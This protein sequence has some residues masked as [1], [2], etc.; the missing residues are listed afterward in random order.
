MCLPC[1]HKHLT[2]YPAGAWSPGDALLRLPPGG[3]TF[4]HHVRLGTVGPGRDAFQGL[5]EVVFVGESEH[6]F[7]GISSR[8]HGESRPWLLFSHPYSRLAVDTPGL[9]SHCALCLE[10]PSCAVM[11][12]KAPG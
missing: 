8:S 10:C 1:C 11:Q 6:T 5:N 4:V 2:L 7:L 3:L 9:R 12:P